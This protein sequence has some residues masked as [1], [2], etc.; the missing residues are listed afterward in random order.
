MRTGPKARDAALYPLELDDHIRRNPT[1]G[2]VDARIRARTKLTRATL[3]I[4]SLPVSALSLAGQ[5]RSTGVS[6]TTESGAART[7]SPATAMLKTEAVI[8]KLT[9]EDRS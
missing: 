7:E 1:G 9:G 2:T 8:G 4:T 6:D 5:N 3:L